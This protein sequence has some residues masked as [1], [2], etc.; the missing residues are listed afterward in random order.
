MFL[1][2]HLE[3]EIMLGPSEAQGACGRKKHCLLIPQEASQIMV[4]LCEK[5]NC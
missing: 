5:Q 1:N 2:M 3:E 4:C